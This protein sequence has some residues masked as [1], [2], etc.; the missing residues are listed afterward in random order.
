VVVGSIA[1]HLF[2]V[3]LRRLRTAEY[4]SNTAIYY[5]FRNGLF[6]STDL[7]SGVKTVIDYNRVR[8]T[9]SLFICSI[10][11]HKQ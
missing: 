4:E 11:S 7:D 9:L 5:D 8:V 1:S 6:A 2:L 10:N 3:W